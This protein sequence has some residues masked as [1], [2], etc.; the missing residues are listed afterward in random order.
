MLA[1]R[2][3]TTTVRQLGRLLPRY[4]S[5]MSQTPIEDAIREKV[6]NTILQYLLFNPSASDQEPR[7][8]TKLSDKCYSQTHRTRNLQ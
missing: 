5:T 1:R 6:T 8:L 7:R 3:H 2:L 4:A